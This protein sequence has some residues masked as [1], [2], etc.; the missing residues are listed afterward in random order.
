MIEK[1]IPQAVID[2]KYAENLIKN[3]SDKIRFTVE[4]GEEL[5]AEVDHKGIFYDLSVVI[6]KIPVSIPNY[7]VTMK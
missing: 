6:I 4:A 1:T 7:M 5:H 3:I 2:P